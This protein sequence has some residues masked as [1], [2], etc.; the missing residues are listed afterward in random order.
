MQFLVI[1][2]T[3][4]RGSIVGLERARLSWA[5]DGH[6]GTL[7]G[8]PENEL[9]AVAKW[10]AVVGGR[11][12]IDALELEAINSGLLRFQPSEE[13]YGQDY[14]E[15]DEFIALEFIHTDDG[16]L[17]VWEPRINCGA[18]EGTGLHDEMEDADDWDNAC[19]VCGGTGYVDGETFETDM[20]G[21]P[22]EPKSTA[23]GF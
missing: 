9:K 18:C 11:A 4:Y 1:D 6:F 5:G 16:T 14:K 15:V 21:D 2:N 8:M 19:H 23:S 20:N 22:P 7:R 17:I 3:G 13:A 12:L 10:C